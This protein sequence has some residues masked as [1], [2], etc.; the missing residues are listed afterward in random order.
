MASVNTQLM[1]QL[2][3]GSGFRAKNKAKAKSLS[4]VGVFSKVTSKMT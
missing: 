1:M 2:T 3:K 4:R